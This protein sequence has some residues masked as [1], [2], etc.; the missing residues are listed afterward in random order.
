MTTFSANKSIG[1]WGRFYY[2]YTMNSALN[3]I[4]AKRVVF[5]VYLQLLQEIW[6]KTEYHEIP[7]HVGIYVCFTGSEVA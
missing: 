3:K 5:A 2:L 4:N 7:A 6:V 1:F